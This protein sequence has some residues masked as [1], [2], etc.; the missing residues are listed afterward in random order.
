VQR[1]TLG[2]RIFPVAVSVSEMTYTVS[3]DTVSSGTLNSNIPYHS[4]RC[5]AGMEQPTTCHPNCF[6]LSATTEDTSI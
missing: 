2:D 4:C 6:I 1:L 3:S 5:I